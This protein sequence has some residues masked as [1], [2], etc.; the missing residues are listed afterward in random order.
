MRIHFRTHAYCQ[1]SH[2]VCFAPATKRRR[3]E[4]II[5]DEACIIQISVIPLQYIGTISSLN[6]PYIQ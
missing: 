1:C 4:S 6:R 5:W 3:S 2:P